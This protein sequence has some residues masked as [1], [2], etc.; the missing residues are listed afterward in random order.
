MRSMRG[1]SQL[2]EATKALGKTYSDAIR[3][4]KGRRRTKRPDEKASASGALNRIPDAGGQVDVRGTPS[5]KGMVE[6]L[7][8]LGHSPTQV[9]KLNVIHVAGTKGKGSTCAFVESF[10]RAY[11]ARTGFPRKTG[12]YTSPHLIYPEER[13]RINF[14][15]LE[16]HLFARYFFEVWDVLAEEETPPRHLQLYALLATHVFLREGVEAAIFETHH[17]GEYD[18]TNFL[19]RPVAT[20]VTPLGMDHASQLGPTLKNIAWHKAGIFKPE[21]PAFSAT[22]D[23]EA[24][25]VLESRA[26]EVKAPLQ[27]IANDPE[28][29]NDAVQL[30]PDVQRGNASV[31]LACVRSFTE[32]LSPGEAL[33]SEDVEKGVAQFTWPGRFQY[34]ARGNSQWFLDGA[35]NEMSVVK[36]AEWFKEA[37]V[38]VQKPSSQT[39]RVLIFGQNSHE[40]NPS[41]VLKALALALDDIHFD[42]II[43]TS[44]N[45]GKPTEGVIRSPV[46]S[47][48]TEVQSQLLEFA[49]IWRGFQSD[50]GIHLESSIEG[51]VEITESLLVDSEG[52]QIFA[53]GSLALV[54]GFL[55]SFQDSEQV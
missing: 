33:L 17:G 52:L 22:Q 47:A 20:I 15:P 28:L 34:I 24:A 5:I 41:D 12:L 38:A 43:L 21:V 42:H 18:A 50:S 32:R 35:H 25:T 48:S 4:L 9:D 53:T 10:L 27:F 1:M 29:P 49:T 14:Q 39:L 7:H 11:G 3:I 6:W 36:A 55:H 8:K 16:R 23:T 19:N 31:A 40:R 46:N 44:G 13:I 2:P 26:A 51:A 37:A 30:K 54:G 45:I